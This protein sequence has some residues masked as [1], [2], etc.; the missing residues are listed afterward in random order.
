MINKLAVAER[1]ITISSESTIGQRICLSLQ[2]IRSFGSSRTWKR[3]VIGVRKY[4]FVSAQGCVTS[5]KNVCV[6]DYVLS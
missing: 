1:Y 6:G 3:A 4:P 5:Q 2:Q